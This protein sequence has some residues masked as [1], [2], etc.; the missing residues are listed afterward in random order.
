MHL[1]TCAREPILTSWHYLQVSVIII[2]ADCNNLTLSDRAGT[3]HGIFTILLSSTL[4]VTPKL[5]GRLIVYRFP[6]YYYTKLPGELY[7]ST[8]ILSYTR[9]TVYLYYYTKLPGELYISTTTK[10]PGELC[11]S[12]TILSYQVNCISLLLLLSYQVN[13]VSLLLY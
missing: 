8:T 12:T 10:L 5:P 2:T 6:H 4:S 3:D 1:V 9:W 13:C 11:I 7:I